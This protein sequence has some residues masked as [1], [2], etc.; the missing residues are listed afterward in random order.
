MVDE[1]KGSRE[2]VVQRELKLPVNL[3]Y[4]KILRF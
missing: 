4:I 3:K 1:K 2:K